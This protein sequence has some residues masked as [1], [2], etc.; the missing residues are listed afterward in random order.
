MTPTRAEITGRDRPRRELPVRAGGVALPVL[1]HGR[2]ELMVE[3][4]GRRSTGDVRASVYNGEPLE[5][6]RARRSFMERF[7][8]A[9]P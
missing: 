2:D 3:L 6:V 7:R 1:E 9:S 4:A 5:A 8:T